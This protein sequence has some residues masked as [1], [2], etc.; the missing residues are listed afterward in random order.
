VQSERDLVHGVSRP[1]EG[2]RLDDQQEQTGA[3]R[4]MQ[5]SGVLCGHP[6]AE[7]AE[8]FGHRGHKVSI[9]AVSLNNQPKQSQKTH[10]ASYIDQMVMYV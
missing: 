3:K 5:H 7:A 10:C 2:Q 1:V 4:G 9:L 6:V 8:R